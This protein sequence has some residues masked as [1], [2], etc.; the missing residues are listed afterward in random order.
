MAP[1]AVTSVAPQANGTGQES[2]GAPVSDKDVS[3]ASAAVSS[4]PFSMASADESV[5]KF[6]EVSNGPREEAI[7]GKWKWV[8]MSLVA[9]ALI[10]SVAF[11]WTRPPAT[12]VVEA[13]SQLTDDQMAKAYVQTDGVY[14]NEDRQGSLD[15][16][17]VS[18]K[19]GPVA[20][21][22]TEVLSPAIAGISPDALSLLVL[23]GGTPVP[24]PVW[25]VPLP[26]GQP[27][28][29]SNL[30]AHE[31]SVTPDGRLLLCNVTNLV[32]AEKDGSNPRIGPCGAAALM[33]VIAYNSPFPPR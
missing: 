16:A 13:I 20:T 9:A 22:P 10:V 26:A 8:A 33:E 6:A 21:I 14:F 12:P 30:E 23:Q 29:V 1:V 24:R 17:Q 11:W 25:E 28:R 18:V 4:P 7:G 19:G 5:A 31:A 27:R 32:I 15:I 3:R 2:L